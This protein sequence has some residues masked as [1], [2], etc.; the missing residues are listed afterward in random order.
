MKFLRNNKIFD[1]NVDRIS[2]NR[3]VNEIIIANR[4]DGI[5]RISSTRDLLANAKHIND[6]RLD[7]ALFLSI[8][9]SG[10]VRTQDTYQSR[11]LLRDPS[12]SSSYKTNTS[13]YPLVGSLTTKN[14]EE[15][16]IMST[17]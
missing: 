11:P 12:L 14:T 16:K 7:L 13:L 1:E 2:R 15:T 6:K 5:I 8:D 10:L 3:N 9:N 4:N 17:C